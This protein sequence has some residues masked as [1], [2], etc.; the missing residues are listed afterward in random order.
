MKSFT[1]MRLP[2]NRLTLALLWFVALASA[3][4]AGDSAQLDVIGFSTDGRIFAFEE[5]GVQDGSGFAYSNIFFIDTQ[6]DKFLPNTPV[7]V[8]VENEESIGKIRKL[9]REKAEP[10]IAHYD[11]ENNP[12]LVVAY[13]PVSEAESNPHR[14]RYYQYP[15]LPPRSQTFTMELKEKAFPAPKACLNMVGAFSG[16]S[17]AFTEAF[18]EPS[19]RVIYEDK[20]VPSSRNCPNGYRLGAVITSELSSAPMVAMIQM[21]SFGFEGNDERWIAVPVRL[22]ETP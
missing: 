1:S 12:G 16:F 7:K 21:S 10:L 11:L 5:Y 19:T 2:Q 18:S 4:Q 8:L 15:S 22:T 20:Q 6:T 13:N 3:A 17:L 14:L 9:A